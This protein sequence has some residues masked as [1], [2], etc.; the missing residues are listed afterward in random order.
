MAIL[1]SLQSGNWSS[2][3]TWGV[4]NEASYLFNPVGDTTIGAAS[5]SS[6]FT[7]GAVTL[8]GL[9]VYLASRTSVPSGTLTAG[10]VFTSGSLVPGASVTV[11][12]SDFPSTGGLGSNVI[13]WTFFKFN[14]P[15]TL[16]AATQYA[17]TLRTSASN[18]MSAWRDSTSG[19]FLRALVTTTNATPS[20]GD[21]VIVVGEYVTANTSN[22]TTVTMDITNSATTFSGV[23]VGLRG[24]LSY[25]TSP[26][27][28]Y[29]LRI[30]GG[31]LILGNLS[32]F[33]I[34]S[35]ATTIPSSST[36][37][38]EFSSS[39]TGNF[40]QNYG[41]T[42][43]AYGTPLTYIS[44]KLSGDVSTGSTTT[45]TDVTTGWNVGDRILVPTTTTTTTQQD[46]L[47]IT[48]ITGT[49]IRHSGYTFAHGGNTTTL[50]QADVLNLTRNVKI[51]SNS[52][53]NRTTN[54]SIGYFSGNPAS[55]NLYYTELY[56]LGSTST[57]TSALQ[58]GNITDITMSGCSMYLTVNS[59]T[60]YSVVYNTATQSAA[61]ILN[62]YDTVFYNYGFGPF[63]SNNIT[64]NTIVNNVYSVAN[65]NGFFIQNR[66]GTFSNLTAAGSATRGMVL[67]LSNNTTLFGMNVT[68][69]NFY[70]NNIALAWTGYYS[71]DLNVNNCRFWRNG[72]SIASSVGAANAIPSNRTSNVV[73][74]NC[75]FF[76]NSNGFT[77]YP[78]GR[79]VLNDCY[80]WGGTGITQNFAINQS[81]TAFGLTDYLTF[82]RCFLGID[83][84]GN[85]SL[86]S[87]AIIS[88]VYPNATASIFVNCNFFGTESANQ[89]G[90]TVLG[91]Y[92]TYFP[93][94]HLSLNHNNITNSHKL[95]SNVGTYTTDTTITNLSSQSLRMT[96][97]NASFKMR[98][99]IFRIPVQSGQTCDV[100]VWVRKS[101]S[102]DGTYYNGSQPRLIYVYN[103]LIGNN[104]ES[105]AATFTDNNLLLYPQ[106]FDNAYWSKSN[107][108]ISANTTSSPDGTISA[109]LVTLSAGNLI[110]VLSR[111]L[112]FTMNGNYVA[113]IYL[114]DNTQRFV[115][116]L[117]G[118]DPNNFANVDLQLG[119]ISNRGVSG[120]ATITNVGNG[121]YRCAFF[122]NSSTAFSFAIEGTTSL[123]GARDTALTSTGSYYAWGAQLTSGTTLENYVPDGTWQQL[124][125]TTPI[126]T[127]TTTCEF[128]VDCDGSTG[129][130][131]V[132]DWSTSTFNDTKGGAYWSNVGNYVEPDFRNPNGNYTFFN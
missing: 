85:P 61:G 56:D 122:I 131:N 87:V 111:T 4:V 102:L 67:G 41:G 91:M 132:S 113:S 62:L 88:P 14:S 107:V 105:V 30:R 39:T 53:T 89:G 23:S 32:T 44:A 83:Y 123:T 124:S 3:S 45:I 43:N 65:N 16:T 98:T 93:F 103:P 60:I 114:K 66:G 117:F 109:D 70:G 17:V 27:T 74:N 55:Y 94:G 2:S 40:F 72:T 75:Y 77:F 47:T 18:Q 99:N 25:A 6:S 51:F 95:Y 20:T 71:N 26:S 36:A 1:A 57:T 49:T 15:V 69:S 63:Y 68:N 110:K 104:D 116:L 129:W 8:S 92:S 35:S 81:I 97:S 38:L 42:F 28:N 78:L 37:R 120:S 126:C 108:T 96:P 118:G 24:V 130:V 9:C 128:Y 73:F 121:W 52:P 112:G 33:S 64:A 46:L 12:V 59:N 50:V 5:Q 31:S 86:F 101:T 84:L 82:N 34:G 7:P 80:I 100:S 125:Y 79:T 22:T 119:I 58:M 115:Q 29:F 90:A 127:A 21:A 13:G 19:N 10:I 54:F 48:G 11:N 76:G 106:D